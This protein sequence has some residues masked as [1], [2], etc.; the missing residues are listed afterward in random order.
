MGTE[1]FIDELA[2]WKE[3]TYKSV[4][5]DHPAYFKFLMKHVFGRE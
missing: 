2:P 1:Y 4:L 3:Y 5:F